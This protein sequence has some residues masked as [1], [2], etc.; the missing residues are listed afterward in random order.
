LAFI[1]LPATKIKRRT[2]I[3]FE[4]ISTAP[5]PLIVLKTCSPLGMLAAVLRKYRNTIGIHN[6]YVYIFQRVFFIPFW[7]LHAFSAFYAEIAIKSIGRRRSLIPSAHGESIPIYT[8]GTYMFPFHQL[9]SA[10]AHG[11]IDKSLYSCH[12]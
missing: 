8:I 5:R 12:T 3:W 2:Y 11:Q 9:C 4:F 7:Q 1:W 10:A 6:M